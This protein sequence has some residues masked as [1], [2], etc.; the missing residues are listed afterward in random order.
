MS[1][2]EVVFQTLFNLQNNSGLK[3]CSA[4]NPRLS[5]PPLQDKFSIAEGA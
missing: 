1:V 5:S 4:G 3:I 2:Y